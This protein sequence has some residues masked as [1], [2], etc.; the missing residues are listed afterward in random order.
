ML[1]EVLR[2]RRRPSPRRT[3]GSP[4]SP[5]PARAGPGASA[6][7]KNTPSASAATTDAVNFSS[8]VWTFGSVRFAPASRARP[9]TGSASG[10]IPAGYAE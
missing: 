1:P 9:T 2:D 3:P 5:A 7:R 10:T 8:R 6:I 4:W